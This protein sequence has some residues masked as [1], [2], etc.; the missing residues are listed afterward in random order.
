VAIAL[1]DAVSLHAQVTPLS[2]IATLQVVNVTASRVAAS[3]VGGPEAIERYD[4]A[5]IAGTG[6]FS[7][8]EFLA[9]LPAAEEGTQ[10]LLLIDG[11]PTFLDPAS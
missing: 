4:D 3:D 6:A 1:L 8:Q 7:V 9:S 11:R 10:Q 2:P 5:Q